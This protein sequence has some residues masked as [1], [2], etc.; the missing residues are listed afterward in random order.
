MSTKNAAWSKWPARWLKSLPNAELE[1]PGGA[2]SDIGIGSPP[3]NGSEAQKGSQGAPSAILRFED[4]VERPLRSS[5]QRQEQ[6][7]G[8]G[9]G[10]EAG[11]GGGPD[12]GD[13][14][15]NQP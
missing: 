7:R 10:E 3:M 1:G 5:T 13:G 4:F 6:G 15:G 2:D 8:R 11:D 9:H 12:G 14:V